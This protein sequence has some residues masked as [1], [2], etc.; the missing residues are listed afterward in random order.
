MTHF[1]CGNRGNKNCHATKAVVR[2][3]LPSGHSGKCA[4]YYGEFRDRDKETGT[5]NYKWHMARW[6]S[7]NAL[8]T[9][10]P[11][12]VPPNLYN[13]RVHRAA[14]YYVRVHGKYEFPRKHWQRYLARE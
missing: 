13:G 12:Y 7:P 6:Y 2:C 11:A 1:L 9:D 3:A 14:P 8:I 5:V 4:A 10:F